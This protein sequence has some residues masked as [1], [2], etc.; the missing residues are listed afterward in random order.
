MSLQIQMSNSVHILIC[1]QI[2]LFPPDVIY[3]VFIDLLSAVRVPNESLKMCLCRM[4][5]ILGQRQQRPC[6]LKRNFWPLPL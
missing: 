6:G 5:I 3:L 1:L 4:Q 2:Y